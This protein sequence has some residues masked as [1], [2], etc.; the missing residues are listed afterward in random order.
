MATEYGVSYPTLRARLDTLIEKI[1]ARHKEKQVSE[2]R[3]VVRELAR[4]GTI[5]LT[6]ARKILAAGQ[7]DVKELEQKAKEKD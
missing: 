7:K 3:R 2:L 1:R 6:H 4:E 5:D